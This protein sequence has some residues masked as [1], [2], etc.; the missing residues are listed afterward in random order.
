MPTVARRARRG[1]KPAQ[2]AVVEE[3]HAKRD[4]IEASSASLHKRSV[5]AIESEGYVRP[6]L[7][8]EIKEFKSFI[9]DQS[10]HLRKHSV[11]ELQ[12]NVRP[13]L[14]DEIKKKRPSIEN[15]THDAALKGA[16]ENYRANVNPSLVNEIKL[17]Q[18]SIEALTHLH[19]SNSTELTAGGE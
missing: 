15:L 5:S 18:P 13:A 14:V 6:A 17:K 1:K 4:D 2:K 7:V 19:R 16:S 10:D 3:L 8:S 11:P 12:K 9:S